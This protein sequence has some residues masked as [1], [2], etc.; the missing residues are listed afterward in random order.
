MKTEKLIIFLEART[1]LLNE[2]HCSVFEFRIL[3]EI[4]NALVHVVYLEF[5]SRRQVKLITIS[6]DFHFTYN[7]NQTRL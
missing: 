2:K 4:I 3:E 7:L 1:L 6:W 5:F